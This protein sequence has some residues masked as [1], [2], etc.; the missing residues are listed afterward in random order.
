MHVSLIHKFYPL[1]VRT[2]HLVCFM[3]RFIPSRVIRNLARPTILPKSAL[4]T[5][6]SSPS[7]GPN[8]T[9]PADE[10]RSVEDMDRLLEIIRTSTIRH[11]LLE[12]F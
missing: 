7:E 10:T 12:I 1:T 6:T 11:I 3:S 9:K 5:V 8:M 2:V 4:R